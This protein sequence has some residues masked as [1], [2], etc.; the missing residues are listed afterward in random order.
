MK[1]EVNFCFV[2]L[3]FIALLLIK[4]TLAFK[5]HLLALRCSNSWLNKLPRIRTE[6]AGRQLE[7]TRSPQ[8]ELS[9]DGKY[10]LKS[11]AH[12]FFLCNDVICAIEI[13]KDMCS[14]GG[15]PGRGKL[16]SE[17]LCS[18][19]SLAHLIFAKSRNSTRCDNL[20]VCDQL[21]LWEGIRQSL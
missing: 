8:S 17:L 6:E 1:I 13:N 2:I 15:Y 19:R 20:W 18:V 3:L 4:P 10:K 7:G 21:V 5:L 9:L 11:I 12:F 16:L 14:K